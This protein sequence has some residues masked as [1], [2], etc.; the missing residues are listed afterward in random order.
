MSAESVNTEGGL[1][2]KVTDVNV[3]VRRQGECTAQNTHIR[4]EKMPQINNLNFHLKK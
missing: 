2:E 1:P 4:K 3:L